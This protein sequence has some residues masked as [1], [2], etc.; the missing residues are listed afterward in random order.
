MKPRPTFEFHIDVFQKDIERAE[1]IVRAIEKE[2]D[3][4]FG[5]DENEEPVSARRQFPK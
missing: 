5:E 2:E 4:D 3:I 1:E